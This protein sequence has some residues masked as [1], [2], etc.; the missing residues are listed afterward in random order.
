MRRERISILIATH[1]RSMHLHNLLHRLIT[2]FGDEL[3]N[4]TAEILVF[5]DASTDDTPA[6]CSMFAGV[7]RFW[8]SGVNVGYMEARRRLI[9]LSGGS[10]LVSLDDDS[11]FVDNRA[12]ETIR[13][14]FADH[15]D[16]SVIA[17]NVAAPHAPAGQLPTTLPPFPVADFIGCGHVLRAAHIRMV[18]NYPPFL[19]GYGAEE[20]V[21]GLRIFDAG[22]RILFVPR[23]RVFHNESIKSR[24]YVNQRASL[25]TNELAIVCYAYPAVLV[26]PV[27]IQKLISHGQFNWRQQSFWPVM[28]STMIHLP[29]ALARALRNR[30][31]VRLRTLMQFYRMR[32]RFVRLNIQ[33]VASSVQQYTWQVPP[34][35]ARGPLFIDG[36]GESNVGDR[37]DSPHSIPSTN[38][39]GTGAP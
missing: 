8:R 29:S 20:T 7:V 13:D 34:Y 15:S 2:M 36:Y 1:N 12:L 24:N 10:Y 30:K 9:K 26:F 14:V 33:W 23:L 32:R 38:L 21:L 18:G 39:A 16:C 19:S 35:D 4:S 28:Y 6:V 22:F 3:A 37:N 31:P 17:A 5:D 25:L 27:V 11:Y